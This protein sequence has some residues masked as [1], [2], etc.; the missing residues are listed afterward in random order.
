MRLTV[1]CALT[2]AAC[3]GKSDGTGY[4][5]DT[6]PTIDRPVDSG[7]SADTSE[8][9]ETGETADTTETAD[10]SDTGETADTTETSDTSDTSDSGDTGT[11]SLYD[12]LGGEKGV[13]AVVDAFVGR[14]AVDP[15]INWM[16]VDA[17]MVRVTTMLNDQICAATGGPC[18]YTG[19]SMV[20]VHAHMAI[21]DAQWDATVNDLLLGLSDVGVPYTPDFSG[22]LP[23][24]TLILA[25]AAMHDEIVTDPSGSTVLFNQ[26]GGH[27]AVQ[28]VVD[29]LITNVGADDRINGFFASTDLTALNGLLVEQICDETGGYCVYHGRDMATTHAGMGICDADFD[30]LVEDLLASM[31]TLGV[32]FTAGTFDG[33]LPADTLILALAGMRADIVDPGCAE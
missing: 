1:I 24:D 26:L 31:T 20:D 12:Q 19:G 8:T 11:A 7:D 2:L 32:P 15:V 18:T 33:G 13:A 14:V 28:A 16:F 27:A 10:T 17:D 30:A 25:L 3:S 6:D 21:T 22:G 5:S 4:S 9:G 23:A 29:G